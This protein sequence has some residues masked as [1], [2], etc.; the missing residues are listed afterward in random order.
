M[1]SER[2]RAT[3]PAAGQTGLK[4]YPPGTAFTG[5][6]GRTI[7]ASEPAWPAPVRAKPGAANVLFIVLDD[8]GFG[9]LGCC[10][11][12]IA[13]P[14]IDRLARNGLLYTNMHTTALCS[15]GGWKTRYERSDRKVSPS[16][17]WYWLR[18]LRPG[19][20]AARRDVVGALHARQ[21]PNDRHAA[22]GDG[23]GRDNRL[24]QG[25]PPLIAAR[26]RAGHLIVRFG[27]LHSSSRRVG[28]LDL[29]P[30]S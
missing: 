8:T 14:N 23:I 3:K 10:G 24:R 16:D 29:A 17:L 5:R 15:S 1:S 30:I 28:D 22:P 26:V 2:D 21:A 6:M 25:D 9:Q 13:T 27:S 11:S 12:P 20:V 7:G 4:E 19:A 18:L